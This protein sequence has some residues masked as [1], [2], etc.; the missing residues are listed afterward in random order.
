MCV[1]KWKKERVLESENESERVS[2][3]EWEWKWASKSKCVKIAREWDLVCERGWV[4]ESQ[5]LPT[6]SGQTIY[7]NMSRFWLAYNIFD[8][9][10]HCI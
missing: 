2:V 4:C 7:H 8:L 10:V 5:W 6:R 3:R 9:Q 1:W